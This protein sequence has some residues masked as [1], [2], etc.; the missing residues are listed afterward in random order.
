VQQFAHAVARQGV[1]CTVIHPLAVHKAVNRKGFP[2]RTIEAVG[3]GRTIEVLRPAFLSL[4]VRKSFTWLGRLNPGLISHWSFSCTVKSTLRQMAT[5]PD[6]LYGHFLN[7]AGAAAVRVGE[8]MGIPAFPGMGESVKHG[9]TIWTVAKYPNGKA[10][11]KFSCVRGLIVNSSLLKRMTAQQ[12]SIPEARI[13]VFPNGIDPERFYPRSKESMRKRFGLPLESFLVGCTGRFSHRKGQQRVLDAMKGLENVGG[14]FIG[15]GVQA[16][17]SV[18]VYFNRAVDHEQVPE[19]LSACDVFVLPTLSEGSSNAI[20]EAMACGLPVVS[21]KG[22]F[23]EDLLTDEISIRV[24]PLD[25]QEIRSAICTL[26]DDPALRARM[27]EAALRRSK[28]FD[29][30]DRARRILNFMTEKMV[31]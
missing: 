28:Q 19:L 24:D 21:S 18:P 7:L 26:R 22:A 31:G 11:C 3:N 23:N 9:N 29:I 13:G 27:A 5:R 20:V 15:S 25:V 1:K 6:V 10:K 12:F 14:I 8:D 17:S 2:F 16:S 4:S 30:N